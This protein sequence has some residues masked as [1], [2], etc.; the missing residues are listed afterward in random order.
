MLP[1]E[2]RSPMNGKMGLNSRR[3]LKYKGD[4]LLRAPKKKILDV[5]GSLLGEIGFCYKNINTS[6]VSERQMLWESPLV[7]SHGWGRGV[8]YQKKKIAATLYIYR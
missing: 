1:G 5:H 7:P 6:H 2:E 8:G 3:D 4:N